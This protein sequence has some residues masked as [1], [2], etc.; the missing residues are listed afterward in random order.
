[1]I[2]SALALFAH[3]NLLGI[4]TIPCVVFTSTVR[5]CGGCGSATV[6][7][8]RFICA[9]RGGHMDVA[10]PHAD[11]AVRAVTPYANRCIIVAKSPT[12]DLPVLGTV[13]KESGGRFFQK[14][15]SLTSDWS[16]CRI[17]TT[18]VRT[19]RSRCNTATRI[20][21]V[22]LCDACG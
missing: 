12:D 10:A 19:S 9:A 7:K 6:A 11:I 5:T 16:H 2:A 22:R 17:L 18:P 8:P 15:L 14:N 3:P 20:R 1:M 13:A 4:S 21:L